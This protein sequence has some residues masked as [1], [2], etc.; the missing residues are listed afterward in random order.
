M[1]EWT[2]TA[3]EAVETALLN[4]LGEPVHPHQDDIMYS[5][6]EGDF[7]LVKRIAATHLEDSFSRSLAYLSSAY[8]LTPNTDTIIAEACRAAADHARDLALQQLGKVVAEAV[9]HNEGIIPV[10]RVLPGSTGSS[11][12]RPT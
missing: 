2:R 3:V 8:K 9:D 5:F 7:E 12:Y 1:Q 10:T 6:K 4:I 11:A